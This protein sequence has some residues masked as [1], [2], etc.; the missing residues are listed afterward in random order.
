MIKIDK[1][2]RIPAVEDTIGTL[3]YY[4][5]V[6]PQYV[7]YDKVMQYIFYFNRAIKIYGDILFPIIGAPNGVSLLNNMK[8]FIATSGVDRSAFNTTSTGNLSLSAESID[9]ALESNKLSNEFCKLL[10]VY[11]KYADAAKSRST[12]LSFL[13]NPISDKV[14]CDGHR[15]IEVRPTW[16]PQNTGRVGMQK[17]AIQNINRNLQD[18]LT[19]P[20]GYIYLHCDSGQ[21]E[22][23]IVY[24]VYIK[25]PQIQTLI[26]LYDDA[27]FG[28]LHYITMSEEDIASGT[29]NFTKREI[30]PEMKENRKKIKTYSN[31]VMYGSKSNP[32]GDPI[33]D[34]FIKRIGE[35]PVRVQLCNSLMQD[36]SMG[37]NIVHT[38]F[39]TPIDISKSAKL[40]SAFGESVAQQKLKLMINNPIQGTAADLMRVSVAEANKIL[41]SK[42]K[43]SFIYNYVHDAACF[44]IAEDEF[45]LVKDELSDIVSYSIDG[46]LPI[47]AEPEIGRRN[48][49]NGLFKDIY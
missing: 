41:I 24:S 16:A 20:K 14:S 44:C 5:S 13:Q 45:D 31:A 40:E 10:K 34:A 23:R 3:T 42:T 25:D 30:T 4:N 43:N 29:L 46:W 2:T 35:H 47:K 33:K 39:G 18:I 32:L 21:I 28:I 8:D 48:G 38:A 7:D 6:M 27:Y 49:E 22:P 12:M 36:I 15:M 17:P 19:V 11:R 9:S 26:N 1:N 37:K